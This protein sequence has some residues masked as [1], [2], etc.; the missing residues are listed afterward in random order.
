MDTLNACGA[1]VLCLELIAPGIDREVTVEAI[2]LC[3]ALL[4]KEGGALAVQKTIF[5]HL[6][7]GGTDYFF[8]QCREILTE[9]TE[10]HK[11]GGE[12]TL[13]LTLTLTLSLTTIPTPGYS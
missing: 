3:V 6:N 7:K 5:G 10:H 12:V 1:T 9:L 4:F 13:T 2:K 8:K 11:W